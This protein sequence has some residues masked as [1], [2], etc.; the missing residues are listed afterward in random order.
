MALIH[1]TPCRGLR[2]VEYNQNSENNEMEFCCKASAVT[3]SKP[4]HVKVVSVNNTQ[5]RWMK[6]R[7]LQNHPNQPH[8]F[9]HAPTLTHSRALVKFFFDFLL[10][11]VS[12]CVI[13]SRHCPWDSTI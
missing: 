13:A 6:N 9:H 1:F 11:P 4:F 3:I 8:H 12:K 10:S 5:R 7:F 2:A